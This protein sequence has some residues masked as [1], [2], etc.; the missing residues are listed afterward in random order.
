MKLYYMPGACPLATHIVLEW[1]GAPYEAVEVERDKLQSPEYLKINP[2][3]L[4]PALVD[5]DLTLTENIAILHYLADLHPDK[6]L[7]GGS[8]P[9]GRAEVNR[10]LGFIN[11]DLHQS[12]KPIFSPERFVSDASQHAELMAN[13]SKKLRDLFALINTPLTRNDWLT[14]TTRSIADAYLFV[15]L[16]WAKDKA[17][18]LSGLD[19][20]ARFS[21]RMQADAGAKAA[22]KAEGL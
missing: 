15:V 20:L 8:T 3:G 5:G 7:A 11:S 1:I 2:T 14:G 21:Q 9:R 19:G 22:M 4:V 13:A 12:F 18:D 17:I 16:R 6:Q 10:W